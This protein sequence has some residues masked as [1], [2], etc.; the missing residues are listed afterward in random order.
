[1][2]RTRLQFPAETQRTIEA[3]FNAAYDKAHSEGR[4]ALPASDPLVTEE[5]ARFV[6][7]IARSAEQGSKLR[8]LLIRASEKER[9]RKIASLAKS[10]ANSADMLGKIDDDA[11]AFLVALIARQTIGKDAAPS[12]EF[13]ALMSHVRSTLI[14]DLKQLSEAASRAAKELSVYKI[15]PALTIALSI[16]RAFFEHGFEFKGEFASQCLETALAAAKIKGESLKH[17]VSKAKKSRGSMAA[18]IKQL[19]DSIGKK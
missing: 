6:R 2:S 18:L 14:S 19:M 16:E 12:F 8:K 10:A 17:Y 4:K 5:R 7:A 1:M 3:G 11:M 9:K 15:N 13:I